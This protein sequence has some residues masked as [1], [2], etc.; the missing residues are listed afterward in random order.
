MKEQKWI[1][2]GLITESLSN[3]MFRVRSDVTFQHSSRSDTI[4]GSKFQET[5]FLFFEGVDS[6]FK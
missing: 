4:G 6:K 3:G 5:Y 2:E 1:H